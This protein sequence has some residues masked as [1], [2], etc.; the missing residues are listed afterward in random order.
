MLNKQQG[1]R[2]M[3]L[4]HKSIKKLLHGIVRVE[5]K[6]SWTTFNRFTASQQD[7]IVK[8]EFLYLRTFPSCSVTLE[9]K[10]NAKS[11]SFDYQFIQILSQDSID[12]WVDG[13]LHSTFAM[14]NLSKKGKIQVELADGE[15]TVCVYFPIDSEIQIKNLIILGNYRSVKKGQKVLWIG[16]SITQGYGTNLTSFTYV[17]VANRIL[18]YEVL[19]QGIGGYIY[20]ANMIQPIDNFKPEKIIVSFGT[21]HY[22][23]KDFEQRAVAFYDKIKEVYGDIPVFSVTPIWRGDFDNGHDPKALHKAG[24]KIMEIVSTRKNHFVADGFTLVPCVSEMFLDNLHP[25][26]LGAEQYGLNLAKVIKK[27]KF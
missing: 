21:N 24:E 26:A 11:F 16:D 9:F 13:F 8:E 10:T 5:K 15:K 22:K 4:S 23:E 6:K 17:N 12:V 18:N 7:A 14:K 20:D 19:N 3:K 2:Q 27:S 1:I 25:N